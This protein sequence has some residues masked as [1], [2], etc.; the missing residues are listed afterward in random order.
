MSSFD[1]D[2]APSNSTFGAIS[3]SKGAAAAAA[4]EEDAMFDNTIE[5]LKTPCN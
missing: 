5:V 2:D 3:I 4:E 1:A